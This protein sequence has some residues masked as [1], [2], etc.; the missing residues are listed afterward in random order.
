MA[1][2]SSSSQLAEIQS[3]LDSFKQNMEENT[4]LELCNKL[5]ELHTKETDNVQ[6]DE[7]G[8]YRLHIVVPTFKLL[9]HDCADRCDTIRLINVTKYA[10]VQMSRE[11]YVN[12]KL[13][14]MDKGHSHYNNALIEEEE[15]DII[16]NN[17]IIE[18]TYECDLYKIVEEG[19]PDYEDDE[20]KITTSANLTITTDNKIC[21]IGI[22]KL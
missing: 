12:I 14:I 13:G 19:E 18:T 9:R 17:K 21:V 22:E 20:P 11:T 7:V 6:Q 15:E 4:Y 5:K 10:I 16:F 8:F 1:S 3:T 2:S